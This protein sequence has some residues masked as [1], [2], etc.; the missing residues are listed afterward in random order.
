MRVPSGKDTHFT[1]F[2]GFHEF[3]R[4]RAGSFNAL[5]LHLHAYLQR[6]PCLLQ[7]PFRFLREATEK[8][9]NGRQNR[10][11]EG[12]FTYGDKDKDRQWVIMYG[13]V[14]ADLVRYQVL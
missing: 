7:M 1:S 4:S 2:M 5:H 8:V 11:R 10:G 13:M 14:M 9:T 3:E 6:P 12:R